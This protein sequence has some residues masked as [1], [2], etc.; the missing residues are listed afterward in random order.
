MIRVCAIV[1]WA[2]RTVLVAAEVAARRDLDR[3]VQVDGQ[4]Q[5]EGQEPQ[6]ADA[7]VP[8]RRQVERGQADQEAGQQHHELLVRARVLRSTSATGR[9][10]GFF[11]RELVEAAP[12]QD[13]RAVDGDEAGDGQGQREQG[14]RQRDVEGCEMKARISIMG[15]FHEMTD[16]E[17]IGQGPVRT[18]RSVRRNAR[19]G[20]GGCAGHPSAAAREADQCLLGACSV[21]GA[22]VLAD[23][24]GAVACLFHG[25]L[26]LF[27][28]HAQ[29]LGPVLDF[30][31][32]VQVDAGAVLLA[33]VLQIVGH[34]GLLF[35]RVR[36]QD[37]TGHGRI[38]FAVSRK[39][40]S[41]IWQKVPMRQQ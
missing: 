21:L 37:A 35:S 11:A 39:A 10:C 24:L 29:R 19:P 14:V 32:L 6:V 27:P 17:S 28:G 8:G 40:I 5:A 25:L 2:S 20:G 36:I 33:A 12:E 4:L 41:F 30:V 34:G 22:Q 7:R 23:G 3:A 9:C 1:T 31:L 13:Q 38:P 16:G 15:S 26:Q 18:E